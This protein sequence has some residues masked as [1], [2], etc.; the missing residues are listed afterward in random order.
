MKA[1]FKNKAT[2]R[3]DDTAGKRDKTLPSQRDYQ[4]AIHSQSACNLTGLINELSRVLP[5]IWAECGDTDAV[6]SHPIVKLY[7]EQIA[8]LSRDIEYPSAHS[9]CAIRARRAS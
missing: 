7:A 6:N 5:A 4:N 3:A 1:K 2:K 9:I 8:H